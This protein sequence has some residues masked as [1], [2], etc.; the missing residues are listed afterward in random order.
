MLGIDTFA[1]KQLSLATKQKPALKKHG[2]RR[3]DSISSTYQERARSRITGFRLSRYL[4]C[5]VGR[6]NIASSPFNV[7]F[8]GFT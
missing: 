3:V 1:V 2:I 6:E 8:L 7:S 4:E 5:Q